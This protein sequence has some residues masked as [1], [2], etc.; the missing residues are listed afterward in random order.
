MLMSNGHKDCNWPGVLGDRGTCPGEQ[1][2]A[3]AGFRSC[4][5][6]EA[7]RAQPQRSPSTTARTTALL[8]RRLMRVPPI[9]G[10]TDLPSDP[11]GASLEE[12]PARH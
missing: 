1:R 7:Q 10:P 6:A 8:E 4:G 9:H 12:G 5:M 3:V 2:D 11:G